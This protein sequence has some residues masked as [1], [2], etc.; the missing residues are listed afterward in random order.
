MAVSDA[1]VTLALDRLALQGGGQCEVQVVARAPGGLPCFS[2]VRERVVHPVVVKV[3]ASERAGSHTDLEVIS[4]LPRPLEAALLKRGRLAF[5][6][7]GIV[8][9]A[10]VVEHAVGR[11]M[12]SNPRVEIQRPVA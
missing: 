10:Q 2:S 3:V 8:H 1:R 6:A 5:T 7:R 9:V 12:L 4:D 11:T